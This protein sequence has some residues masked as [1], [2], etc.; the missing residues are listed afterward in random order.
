MTLVESMTYGPFALCHDSNGKIIFVENVCPG[1]QID[2]EIYDEHKDFAYAQVSTLISLSQDRMQ[3]PPCKIHKICGSC[4]WQ[5]IDYP[6][7]LEFKRKNLENLLQKFQIRFSKPIPNLIAMENP[8][9]YRNKVIYPVKSNSKTLKAGYF[10]RNSHELINIKF[11]PIQYSIFDSIIETIKDL[12]LEHQ[13]SDEFL[14]HILLRSNY[15]QSQILCSF[16]V[17][18]SLPNKKE[19]IKLFK[20]LRSKFPNILGCTLNYNDDSTNVILGNKTEL[21]DGQNY[22]FENFLGLEFKISTESFFQINT[23]QFEKIIK[24]IANQIQ[25]ES[26]I[27]DAYCGTGTI[28][29]SLASLLPKLRI[30]GIE[31]IRSA[32]DDAIFNAQHNS[33]PANF[34]HSKVEDLENYSDF[35]HIILNPPRRGLHK[36]FIQRFIQIQSPSLIYLS[37]NPSTLCRDLKILENHYQLEQIIPI[38]MFPHSFHFETLAILKSCKSL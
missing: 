14:R 28:S 24:L 2:F 34:L 38:D 7:Q 4:Q 17:R 27:L 12:A 29:L 26:S 10:K 31:S 22:I 6:A 16:I 5:H 15:D 33:I 37:C 25:A 19:I 36:N 20:K 3:N 35:D 11:C 13:I 32:V 21:I 18:S 9:N 1:D 30:T 8:W 23:L